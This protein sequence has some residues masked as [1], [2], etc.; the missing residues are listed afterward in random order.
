MTNFSLLLCLLFSVLL[1]AQTAS[2][3]AD[4]LL[5]EKGSA[6]LAKEI[7]YANTQPLLSQALKGLSAQGLNIV[8]S[9]STLGATPAPQLPPGTR[10]VGAALEELLSKTSFD[11][12]TIGNTIAIVEGKVK[13]D[14]VA[15]AVPK[16][17]ASTARRLPH[18]FTGT[19]HNFSH[20]PVSERRRVRRLLDKEL[21]GYGLEVVPG[22]DTLVI[23]PLPSYPLYYVYANVGM[24]LYN[25][26]ERSQVPYDWEDELQYTAKSR[27]SPRLEL[28]MEMQQQHYFISAGMALQQLGISHSWV[29]MKKNGNMVELP[30][31]S[32]GVKLK[33]L[34]AEDRW[35]LFSIPVQAGYVFRFQK[36]TL[37]PVFGLSYHYMGRI[38]SS[39]SD[40]FKDYYKVKSSKATYSEQH[41]KHGLSLSWSAHY[42]YSIQPKIALQAGLGYTLFMTAIARNPIFKTYPD[43]V[44]LQLGAR[45]RIQ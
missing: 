39:A 7:T 5:A 16:G 25:L 13:P 23:K 27:T 24:P 38:L 45:Y 37:A 11:Y 15:A 28:G 41:P 6:L 18:V 8:Y 29:E 43:F 3:S 44:T 34:N 32:K 30:D 4:A 19:E 9:S 10:S 20:I 21:Q 22:K 1:Q 36:H 42:S 31:K 12:I 26:R 14:T 33:Y 40:K 35:L 17:T 2:E